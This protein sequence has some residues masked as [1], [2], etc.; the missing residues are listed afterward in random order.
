MNGCVCMCLC[1][2]L[3]I[4]RKYFTFDMNT[5]EHMSFAFLCFSS[6]LFSCSYVCVIYQSIASQLSV[7]K[8]VKVKEKFPYT[9]RSFVL[10]FFFIFSFF[11][12]C[13]ECCIHLSFFVVSHSVGAF[14]WLSIQSIFSLKEDTFNILLRHKMKLNF[15]LCFFDSLYSPTW[16]CFEQSKWTE[17]KK[18]TKIRWENKKQQNENIFILTKTLSFSYMSFIYTR[19]QI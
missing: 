14:T 12:C 10:F 1:R 3:F 16:N 19:V 7:I 17:R 9:F 15:D 6:F 11:I 4:R 18:S 2:N 8:K 5:C 13:L